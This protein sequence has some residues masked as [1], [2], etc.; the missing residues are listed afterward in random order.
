MVP[1]YSPGIQILL[2]NLIDNAIRYTPNNGEVTVSLTES[3]EAVKISVTDSGPGIPE[4][5]QKELYQ[6]F[7]RG[8]DTNTQGSGLGLAIVKRIID[9]HQAT[10]EMKNREDQSGLSVSVLFPT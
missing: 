5:K 10:I 6:R 1:G 7:R 3:D 8:E 4:A 2:R 9:L